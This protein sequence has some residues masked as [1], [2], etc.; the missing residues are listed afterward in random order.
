MWD[1]DKDS[2]CGCGGKCKWDSASKE[3]KIAHLEK[4]EEKLKKMLSHI[5][6]VKEAV[7]SGKGSSLV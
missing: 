7:K 5:E 1:K 3:E 2:E 4:K 6:K